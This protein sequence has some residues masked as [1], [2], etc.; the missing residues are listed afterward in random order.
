MLQQL[1][2]AAKSIPILFVIISGILLL[3]SIAIVAPTI[4]ALGIV[5]SL[6]FI[7]YSFTG[8]EAACAMSRNIENPTKNAPKAIFYSFFIVIGIYTVFQL[9]MAIMLMPNIANLISYKDAFPYITELLNSSPACKQGLTTLINFVIGFSMLGGAYGII[10]SNSWNLLILAE[11]GHTFRPAIFTKLNKHNIPV[12]AVMAQGIICFFFILL[13]QG[14]QIPLQQTAALGTIIAY[15]ISVI[16]FMAQT[17]TSKIMP[18]I[19]LLTCSGLIIA[20]ILSTI[21]HGV[22]SL[23]LFAFMSLLGLIMYL[24]SNKQQKNS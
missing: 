19:A 14:A 23:A 11:H 17:T 16:A 12:F 8:F 6:P 21:K 13:T 5:S 9:L 1:F 22:T 24:I 4:D 3:P 15:T 2:F 20:Y 10:F 7:L 18:S